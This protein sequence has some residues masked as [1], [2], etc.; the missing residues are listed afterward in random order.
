MPN[1]PPSYYPIK[2]KTVTL[3]VSESP[4]N[5][6]PVTDPETAV[7]F[8][9]AVFATLDADREHFVIL[10]LGPK[11]DPRGFKVVSTGGT[12]HSTI[13]PKNLWRD[14]L[15][16]GAAQLILAHNHPGGDPEPSPD[17]VATTTRI[18]AGGATLGISVNDHIILAGEKWLSFLRRGL[19]YL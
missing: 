18:V 16:L 11:N 19:M 3:H 10:A 8:L 7:L 5:T 17:D 15:A 14:A 4:P 2:L 1:A 6:V 9:R 12:S 13:D